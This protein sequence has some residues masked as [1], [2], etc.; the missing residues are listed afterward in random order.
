MIQNNIEN[1]IFNFDQ[2]LMKFNKYGDL[3]ITRAG[4]TSLAEIAFLNIFHL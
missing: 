2:N 3:C 1:K 4:A